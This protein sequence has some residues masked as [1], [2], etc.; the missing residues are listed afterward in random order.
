MCDHCVQPTPGQLADL[1]QA[2]AG[3]QERLDGLV[4]TIREQ[5]DSGVDPAL[6]CSAMARALFVQRRAGRDFLAVGLAAA[7]LRL[8]QHQ[9][10][11]GEAR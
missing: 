8:A 3:M 11:T 2:I 5:L 4:D 10:H 7:A 1:D 9:R 6:S